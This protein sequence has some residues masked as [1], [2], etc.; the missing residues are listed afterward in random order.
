MSVAGVVKISGG[1]LYV[2]SNRTV[3]QI[4][5]LTFSACFADITSNGGISFIQLTVAVVAQV[6]H[7][8]SSNSNVKLPLVVNVYVSDHPLFVIVIT[9]EYHVKVATTD[10]VMGSVVLYSICAIG[11]VVS[12]SQVTPASKVITYL[13]E[14]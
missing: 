5:A 2:S 13:S 1:E 8:L 4:L 6:F 10:Q 14:R 3:F 7:E 12:P 11:G 9:S